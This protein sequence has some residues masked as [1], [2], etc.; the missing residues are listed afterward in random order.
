MTTTITCSKCGNPLSEI[1]H[2]NLYKCPYCGTEYEYLK[3][4]DK[5]KEIYT[6]PCDTLEVVVALDDLA[7][8]H[9]KDTEIATSFIVDKFKE[10]LADAIKDYIRVVAETDPKYHQHIFRGYIR[11]LPKDFKFK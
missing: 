4:D 1:Y 3:H 8:M 5:F 7:V 11:V 10:S 2:N 6:P 9:M